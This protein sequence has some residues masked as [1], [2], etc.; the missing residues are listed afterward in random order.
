MQNTYRNSKHFIQVVTQKYKTGNQSHREQNRAL[1]SITIIVLLLQVLGYSSIPKHNE[2]KHTHTHNKLILLLW[3]NNSI[4]LFIQ[5]F[6]DI[7]VIIR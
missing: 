4:I 7:N 3:Y 2:M 5:I 1:L 6:W